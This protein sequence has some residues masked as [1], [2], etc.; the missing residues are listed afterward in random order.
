V[1]TY[2]FNNKYTVAWNVDNDIYTRKYNGLT[3]DSPVI[4]AS[5]SSGGD[6]ISTMNLSP[7]ELMGIWRKPS[8]G[9]TITPNGFHQD[10]QPQKTDNTEF[11]PV[12]YRLNKHI[13]FNLESDSVLAQKGYKGLIAFEVAGLGKITSSTT[14]NIKV[15]Q[16]IQCLKSENILVNANSDM[17]KFAGAYYAKGLEIPK[18][19]LLN[20]L[21]TMVTLQL[22]DA[23]TNEVLEEIW[24]V[25]F[26]RLASATKTDGEYRTL[27]IPLNGL[28]GRE[29]YIDV[30]LPSNIEPLFVDDYYIYK[31]EDLKMKKFFS[32]PLAL[33]TE[34]ALHQNYP[35]PFNPSTTIRFDLV[36]PQNVTMKVYNSLGQEVMNLVNEYYNAGSHEV[37]LNAS[38]LSSG[39][40]FYRMTAGEYSSI[41]SFM[42]VK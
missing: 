37:T 7:S 33:P 39:A 32:E 35:N 10:Q 29:V 8:G 14:S 27:S 21:S 24:S 12:T 36:E 16:S 18:D 2:S 6:N 17:L 28:K 11:K 3:W 23:E 34:Y 5:G 30:A 15:E 42:L 40:Y 1:G 13:I 9:I 25:P 26:S 19:A 4:I 22:K 31:G 20:E 38:S 41:K